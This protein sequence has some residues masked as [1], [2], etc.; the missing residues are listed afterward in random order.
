MRK[1][2]W[3]RWVAVTAGFLIGMS[4]CQPG[5]EAPAGVR[6]SAGSASKLERV[7]VFTRTGGFRHPSIV[8][9]K[10]AFER[11]AKK[12]GFTVHFTE[13]PAAFTEAGLARYQVVV[14]LHTTGKVLD[15]AGQAALR[16]W[17]AK[18]NGW[19]GVHG[20]ADGDRQWTWYTGLVGATFTGHSEIV[21]AVVR[22]ADEKHPATSKLPGAW[23][24][25]DEWYN[26][27]AS[28]RSTVHVLATVD[29]RTFVGGTMG[30]DHPIAWCQ[31]YDGGRS[32]YTALGHTPE[33]WN[34]PLFL[35]HV[36]G[37][38]RWAA[39]AGDDCAPG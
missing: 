34:E 27:T 12:N 6:S 35:E 23:K 39:G 29:E 36:L 26:F 31:H 21:P 24:R 25:T 28:L 8:D 16:Q 11:L 10:A 30:A 4:A 3:L 18:G 17:L 20:A 13:D 15:E 1:G 37:G 32:F 19:V 2:P 22:V 9:G 7:L 14:F 5:G 38:V 33:S